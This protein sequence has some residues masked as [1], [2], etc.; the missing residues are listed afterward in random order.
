[1]KLKELSQKPKLIKLTITDEQ[2]V[3]KYGDE[4]EF[5]VYDRQPIDVFT[6]LANAGENNIGDMVEFMHQLILDEDGNPVSVEG[7]ILPMDVTTE[8]I[9][10]VSETLGK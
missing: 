4:L 6:K 10:L 2:L 5:Y 8:A 9:R 7:E 1:M 3:E